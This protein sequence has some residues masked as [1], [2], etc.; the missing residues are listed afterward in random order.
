MTNRKTS[1]EDAR[2]KRIGPDTWRLI[3]DAWLRDH[4]RKTINDLNRISTCTATD[5]E[6]AEWRHWYEQKFG[7]Q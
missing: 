1:A 4:P 7:Q 5:P 3:R 6:A 2:L